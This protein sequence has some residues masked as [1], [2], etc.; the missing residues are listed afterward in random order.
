MTAPRLWL[1][2][3]LTGLV[4]FPC[5][6][7]TADDKSVTKRPRPDFDAEGIELPET[8]LLL[9]PSL[10]PALI[11]DSNALR[12]ESNRRGDFAEKTAA[13]LA[14]QSDEEDRG[15]T[16]SADGDSTRYLRFPS[17]NAD[18]GRLLQRGFIAPTE[19]TRIGLD[20]SEEWLVQP[21]ED[22]GDGFRQQRPTPYSDRSALLTLGYA[23]EDWQILASERAEAYRFGANPPVVIGDELDRNEFTSTLH[24]ARQLFEGTALYIEPE[25]NLRHY[26]R[27]VG[28]DGLRHSSS[29]GQMVAGLR[30]D[31]SSVTFIEAGAGWLRQD[32][33]DHAFATVVGPALQGRA[34][35]NPL[36]QLSFTVLATRRVG[37]SNLPN[38]AGVEFDLGNR[39]RRLRDRRQSAGRLQ[40]FL[41]RYAIQG[42][43]GSV[44]PNRRHCAI[45]GGSALSHRP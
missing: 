8:D 11:A 42:R 21:I 30:Y 29:G 37:E 1:L 3:L 10:Q 12:T 24:I 25:V 43:S 38:T 18:Q 41:Y 14:L 35:W 28:V 40:L 7:Q 36:D 17:Q 9:F 19:E 15:W 31:L 33:A 6:G 5:L 45:W 16:L 26:L 34:V 27:E 4:A 23:D 39:L 32:Y 44:G 20:L 22:S 13:E 2:P